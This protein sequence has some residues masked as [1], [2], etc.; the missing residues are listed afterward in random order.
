MNP[1]RTSV[2][3]D[4]VELPNFFII[5][6][7]KSGTTSLSRYLKDHPDIYFS[8]PKEPTFF[9]TDFSERYRRFTSLQSYLNQCFYESKGFRARGEGTVWYLSSEV[10]VKNILALVPD[11]KFIVMLRNPIEIAHAMHATELY[12]SGEQ[13]QDFAQAWRLMDERKAGRN[14]PPN[15]K[16]PKILQYGDIAKLGQQMQRLLSTVR[17]ENVLTILFEDFKSDTKAVYDQTISFLGLERDHRTEFPKYNENRKN[18]NEVLA[19]IVG[20]IN[21]INTIARIKRKL[22]FEMGKGIMRSIREANSITVERPSLPEH[23]KAEM[24]AYF[25]EDILL[26]QKTINR[27]LSNWLEQ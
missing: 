27:D 6:A 21:R 1:A 11:A 23:L 15:C 18:K 14:I 2:L 20:K 5:G 12:Y 26:L 3:A 16:E 24:K 8:H 7:P 25:K 9:C 17:R 22:G 19:R 13:V 10:A 4:H